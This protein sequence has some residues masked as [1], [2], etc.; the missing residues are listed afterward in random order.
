[1]ALTAYPIT[2]DFACEIGDVDLGRLD[3]A[4]VE[5][6]KQ[7]FWT[8]GVLIF[9]DQQLTAEQHIAFALRFGPL[10]PSL[11]G[12]IKKRGRLAEGLIDVSNVTGNDA[13]WSEDSRLRLLREGDKLWHTDSSFLRTPALVSILYGKAVSPV[14]GF[15]EFADERAAYDA[16]PEETKARLEGLVAR[17]SWFASRLRYGL[18]DFPQDYRD[19]YPPA[20]QMLVR[21]LPQ[22]GRRTLYL[23]A[24][25]A[26]IVGMADTDA[27]QLV[28]ELIA[29]ATQ[30][31]FVYRHRWRLHDVVMWDNRCTMHRGTPFED[32]RWKR[33]LQRA[34]ASDVANS[35]EQAGLTITPQM[36]G[37]EH[38]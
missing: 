25:I 1:M 36:D 28:D 29:H 17:H 14:G 33:D 30:P 19:R 7:A 11:G 15:T 22:T 12:S 13:L 23:A 3:D 24:H 2:P 31:Q 37:L 27:R 9:P 5:A 21:T 26:S 35:V 20:P 6:I 38:A 10:D 32:T 4:Q 8:Y 18:D 34:S 16:L